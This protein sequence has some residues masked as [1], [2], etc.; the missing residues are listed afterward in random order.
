MSGF[1]SAHQGHD[2]NCRLCCMSDI[3]TPILEEEN[4]GQIATECNLD[5]ERGEIARALHRIVRSMHDGHCPQCGRLESADQFEHHDGSHSCP[6]CNFTITKEQAEAALLEFRPYLQK[7]VEV[8]KKWRSQFNQQKV[9]QTDASEKELKLKKLCGKSTVRRNL[10]TIPGYA[11]YCNRTLL[12]CP[13][14]HRAIWSVDTSR[15]VCSC[16][17]VSN[18]SDKFTAAYVQ[19]RIDSQVCA[20]CGVTVGEN[21]QKYCGDGSDKDNSHNWKPPRFSPTHYGDLELVSLIPGDIVEVFYA[22]GAHARMVIMFYTDGCVGTRT[23]AVG[24]DG[25][26]ESVVGPPVKWDP[27]G[28]AMTCANLLDIEERR[29]NGR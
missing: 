12:D 6:G 26:W 10:L 19:Y 3:E 4:M 15:F 28:L 2:P 5:V 14:L 21:K 24:A 25:T 7:S 9:A 20:K 17:W 8:F 29:Y 11:P 13:S 1:C 23:M 22:D 16:G 18:Y 27:T